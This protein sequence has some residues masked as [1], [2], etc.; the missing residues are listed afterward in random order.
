MPCHLGVAPWC[1]QRSLYGSFVVKYTHLSNIVAQGKPTLWQPCV[2]KHTHLSK[3]IKSEGGHFTTPRPIKS[4]P[5][6]KIIKWKSFSKEVNYLG[7]S[8]E[9]LNI[10]NDDDELEIIKP[11]EYSKIVD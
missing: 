9:L 11:K 10:Q 3:I 5:R 8:V 4:R 6:S 1:P 2:V 7:Y